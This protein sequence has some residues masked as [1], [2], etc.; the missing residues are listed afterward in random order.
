MLDFWW[1]WCCKHQSLSRTATTRRLAAYVPCSAQSTHTVPYYLIISLCQETLRSVVFVCWLD[2][3]SAGCLCLVRSFVTFLEPKISKTVGNRG[4]V[5][6]FQIQ[7]TTNR[8]CTWRIQWS[9]LR[10]GQNTTILWKNVQ[11][12]WGHASS[13]S[14]LL[15]TPVDIL[16]ARPWHHD[17]DSMRMFKMYIIVISRKSY[18]T[19]IEQYLV[20]NIFFNVHDV[21]IETQSL[22]LH[23]AYM[24][25]C[26]CKPP[27]VVSCHARIPRN[28]NGPVASR[29]TLVKP[30]KK[31][32]AIASRYCQPL[33]FH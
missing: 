28:G 15:I 9:V 23:C 8:N 20:K 18:K 30:P 14:P 24:E 13:L 11:L 32:Q 29:L 3:S 1:W 6:R 21:R 7:W 27:A 33:A 19:S 5:I 2:R 17:S 12:W 26:K 4:S 22:R 10:T 16:L 25:T 31:I